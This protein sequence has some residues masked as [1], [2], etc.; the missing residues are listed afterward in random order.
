MNEGACVFPD[1]NTQGY[2]FSSAV[3]EFFNMRSELALL[4]QS[5]IDVD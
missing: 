5:S 3:E 4:C 1:R 2:A